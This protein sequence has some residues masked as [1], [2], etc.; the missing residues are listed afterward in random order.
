MAAFP[1]E[2]NHARSIVASKE[3]GCTKEVLEI[4]SVLSSTSKVFLDITEQRDAAA[5]ARKMFRHHTGDH[6][7][8]LNAV[9]AFQDISNSESRAARRDWCRSHFLNERTLLEASKI[10]EQLAR[11]CRRQ[12]IDPDVSCGDQE[13]PVLR[14]MHDGLVHQTALLRPDKSYKQVM[15]QSV[16]NFFLKIIC[17]SSL[18]FLTKLLDH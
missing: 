3:N 16:R 18:T 2:P 11:T 1:V 14:C 15:G 4:I 8:I 6:M 9:R 7:S 13:E 12:G 5:E 10:R 17:L